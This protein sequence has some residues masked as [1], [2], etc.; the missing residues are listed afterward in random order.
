MAKISFYFDE[1][2][3]REATEQVIKRGQ[4]VMMAVDVGMVQ[5][6]DDTEH[7]PYAKNHSRVLVTFD[8][9]FAGRT[10]AK[11]DH[12]G[13]ICLTCK[14]DDVGYIVRVLTEF[15]ELYTPD[16]ATGQVFWL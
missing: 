14:Q 13:L 11:T 3:S 9:P 4:D 1:M 6:D 2:M 5:K 10:L 7:L 15:A 12:A 8:L 16:D